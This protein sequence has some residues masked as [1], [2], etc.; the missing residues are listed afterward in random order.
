M[1]FM[2]GTCSATSIYKK[3]VNSKYAYASK[4][5]PLH[6]KNL[7]WFLNKYQKHKVIV[8]M[9]DGLLEA[10][11]ITQKTL[12]LKPKY[13]HSVSQKKKSY[14]RTIPISNRLYQAIGEYLKTNDISIESNS[15][16]S[17]KLLALGHISRKTMWE[18]LK[19][20]QQ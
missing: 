9:L 8:L 16:F 3:S 19:P 13:Y 20:D 7:R 15:F 11:S 2:A 10:C 4:A 17:F 6:K 14:L 1:G 5:I 12:I 18:A